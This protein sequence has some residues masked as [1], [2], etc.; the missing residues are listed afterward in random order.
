[1]R[2]ASLTEKVVSPIRVYNDRSSLFPR[3]VPFIGGEMF[4]MKFE[5]STPSR[6]SVLP[7]LSSTSPFAVMCR[8]TST[9][10][11]SPLAPSIRWL[12]LKAHSKRNPLVP[13]PIHSLPFDFSPSLHER[14]ATI[15]S[16]HRF[17][18]IVQ[19]TRI[20]PTPCVFEKSLFIAC[21]CTFDPCYRPTVTTRA[22]GRRSTDL[23]MT[24]REIGG[25]I[26]R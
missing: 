1:M 3:L 12:D 26:V 8:F 19:L 23:E 14:Y 2:V 18:F 13:P 15:G 16:P 9:R 6:A 7:K 24:G 21:A 17:C 22:S 20:S 5:S 11:S 10:P 25:R 4:A